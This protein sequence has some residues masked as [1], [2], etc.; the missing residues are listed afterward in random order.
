M[1]GTVHKRPLKSGEVRWAYSF[2]AGWI[3]KDGVRIRDQRTKSGFATK[4]EAEY[5]LRNAIE[6]QQR[7]PVAERTI[8]TFA[9]FFERWDRECFSRQCAPKTAERYRELGQYFLRLFGDVALDQ[10]ENMTMELQAAVNQL[11]DHGGQATKKYPKGRPLAEKTVR[12]AAFLVQG[13]LDQALDWGLISKNPMEKVK[14]PKVPRRR[15]K[16]IDRGGL[17]SLLRKTAGTHIFPL[18]VVG[19]ATGMRRGELLALQWADLD[20]DKGVLEVS[21]SLEET[22]QGLRVKSTKSGE[23]RRFFIPANVLDVLR[24]HQRDQQRDR[25][26]Y[27]ADYANLDLIF[28]RPDGH[29]YNPDKLGVRVRRAMQASGLHG[30]SLH[31]LRHSHASELLSQGVPITAVAER[32]G[33][34]SPNITLSIYSHALPA[35]NQ[36]AAKLWN[37]A[38][39][40]VIQESRKEAQRKRMLANVSAEDREK[41][42]I[43]IKSAS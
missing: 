43:P 26:K 25:E 41:K 11:S 15:P 29:Y 21:K 22:K 42:I 1:K 40:D 2:F 19:A 12:N 33:H 24:E 4:R 6:E 27:G 7:T 9:D 23:S 37:D 30:V 34:A 32:L 3:E 31:S 16:V 39:A 36:A 10:L 8:P 17:D 20:W 5:A 13:C 14:K 35:D 38:M 28:A 18:I